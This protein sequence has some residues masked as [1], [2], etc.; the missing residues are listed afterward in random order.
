MEWMSSL[1]GLRTYKQAPVG[2]CGKTYVKPVPHEVI[3]RASQH[4]DFLNDMRLLKQK[5][6]V[7]CLLINVVGCRTTV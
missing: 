3:K 5:L 1:S 4:P 2:C 7:A 6:G